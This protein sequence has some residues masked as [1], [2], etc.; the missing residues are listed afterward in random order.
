VLGARRRLSRCRL[1]VAYA[2]LVNRRNKAHTGVG[3]VCALLADFGADVPYYFLY[4]HRLSWIFSTNRYSSCVAE[5]KR[6]GAALLDLSS[7]NPVSAGFDY[8]HREISDAFST[9]QDF[10]YEPDAA[11][12]RVAREAVAGYYRVRGYDVPLDRIFLTASTSEA[13]S[14]LFKLLCDPGD[15]VLTPSPSYPLF[16]YL[17]AL[18]SVRPVSYRLRYDGN[19]H[20]DFQTLAERVTPRTRAI[21][22]V[23]PNNPTGS[24]LTAHDADALLQFAAERGLAVIADEVFLDYEITDARDRVKTFINRNGPLIFSLNG[25][26]KSAGMPQMKLGWMVLSGPEAEQQSARERLELVLDTYLSVNTPVQAS[27]AALLA[28]GERMAGQILDRTRTN[29]KA[30]KRQLAGSAAHP[31]HTEGGWSAIVQL[32]HTRTED[33]WLFSFLEE[34]KVIAQPGYYFDMEAE[35]YLVVSLITP[36]EI[37][38]EGMA[39]LGKLTAGH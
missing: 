30:L 31:L 1:D 38:A 22:L 35:A 27:A 28:V 29:Y 26:S 34:Q 11:G 39:R 12:T 36:P 20:V 9:V 17:A 13:Y 15:E 5:L 23:N 10:S 19:W 32:P 3:P 33:E 24:F 16:E 4:S 2:G 7:S 37:F 8:P 18:D 14:Q 25:L 21:I 6:S